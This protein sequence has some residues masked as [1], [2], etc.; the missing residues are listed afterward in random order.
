[1]VVVAML[2]VVVASLMVVVAMLMV[3]VAMLMVVVAMLMVVQ[4]PLCRWW[5]PVAVVG[6]HRCSWF[7]V[8]GCWSLVMVCHGGGQSWC[9]LVIMFI[10]LVVV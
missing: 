9:W 3:V 10:V 7:F 1:M 6:C 8:A 5:L 2:M 4:W